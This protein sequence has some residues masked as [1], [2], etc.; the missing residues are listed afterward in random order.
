MFLFSNCTWT[1]QWAVLTQSSETADCEVSCWTAFGPSPLSPAGS[2]KPYDSVWKAPGLP[3]NGS[4]CTAENSRL[5]INQDALRRS[6]RRK[7]TTCNWRWWNCTPWE[8]RSLPSPTPRRCCSSHQRWKLL[9]IRHTY[10]ETQTHIILRT[11]ISLIARL[12]M[13]PC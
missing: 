11:S 2:Q 5:Y 10:P 6:Q 3:R 13:D 4:Y 1:E 12:C 7:H 9:K 8:P